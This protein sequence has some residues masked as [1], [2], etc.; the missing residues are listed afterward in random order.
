MK[1]AALPVIVAWFGVTGCATPADSMNEQSA[2]EP[3]DVCVVLQP[4]EWEGA[5][6][7]DFMMKEDI[8]EVAQAAT[9]AGEACRAACATSYAAACYRVTALCAGA[10]VVTIG[11]ATVAC[12][13]AIPAVCLSSV[14]LASICNGQCPS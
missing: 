7:R 6:L 10:E 14:A 13:T 5:E 9:A 2:S 1:E 11:G 12:A 8:G 4:A 3:S